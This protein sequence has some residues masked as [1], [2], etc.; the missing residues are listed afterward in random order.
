[1]NPKSIE[2]RLTALESAQ[3]ND[4]PRI[5]YVPCGLTDAQSDEIDRLCEEIDSQGI[6]YAR[7]NDDDGTITVS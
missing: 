4:V 6:L 7:I 5:I 2:A 3:H 1:M